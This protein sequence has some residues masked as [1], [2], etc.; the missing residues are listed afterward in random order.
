MVKW[1]VIYEDFK[2][3]G[4]ANTLTILKHGCS[5]GRMTLTFFWVK[6]YTPMKP[7]SMIRTYKISIFCYMNVL[8][9]PIQNVLVQKIHENYL[10]FSLTKLYDSFV[11]VKNL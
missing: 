4:T 6:Y 11:G 8:S 5:H 10:T 7:C 9:D 3:L 2:I 1:N